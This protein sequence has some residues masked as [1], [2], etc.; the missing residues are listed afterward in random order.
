M[1]FSFR[2]NILCLPRLDR[3]SLSSTISLPGLQ[4]SFKVRWNRYVSNCKTKLQKGIGR[5]NWLIW[6]KPRSWSYW[7]TVSVIHIITIC[8]SALK[9]Q[10]HISCF[11]PVRALADRS[12]KGSAEPFGRVLVKSCY[13][14]PNSALGSTQEHSTI[15]TAWSVRNSYWRG[16]KSYSHTFICARTYAKKKHLKIMLLKPKPL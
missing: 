12:L 8:S 1:G 9:H 15:S 11:S 5:N 2:M 6:C 10:K 7:L 16:V 3:Q 4:H 13:V 14:N